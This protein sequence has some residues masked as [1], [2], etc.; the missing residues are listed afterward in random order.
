MHTFLS[1][2]SKTSAPSEVSALAQSIYSANP[3][4]SA[5]RKGQA[6]PMSIPPAEDPLLAYFVGSITK[7]GHRAKAS[8]TISRM[9]LY[10]RAMTK[11]PALPVLR[12]AVFRLAPAVKVTYQRRGAKNIAR[13]QV[14][15][16]KQRVRLAVQWM[17]K[18]VEKGPEHTLEE[19]LAR[20]VVSII[21]G[22][23]STLKSQEE[24]H[25][26]AMVNRYVPGPVVMTIDTDDDSL[27]AG[28]ILPYPSDCD[29][30]SH[31]S[32]RPIFAEILRHGPK[33]MGSV[34]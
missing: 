16:E 2:M 4:F 29:Y 27:S 34:M 19:R 12:E 26:L 31:T 11:S 24:L 18:K 33:W 32:N 1:D 7:D 22:T 10:I 9:M 23:S 13:P 6:A 28:A 5:R 8:R 25:L 3:S 30:C 17:L 15:S 20:E 14:L 21:Q